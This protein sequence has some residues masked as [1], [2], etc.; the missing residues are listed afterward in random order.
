MEIRVERSF[1]AG[2]QRQDIEPLPARTEH[3]RTHD[4]HDPLPGVRPVRQDLEH[5][6]SARRRHELDSEERR[7]PAPRSRMRL[8]YVVPRTRDTSSTAPSGKVA[9][10]ST[11]EPDSHAVRIAG[12][13]MCSNPIGVFA[14]QVPTNALYQTVILDNPVFATTHI[15]VHSA[16][17]E[18]RQDIGSG[19][20]RQEHRDHAQRSVRNHANENR[21]VLFFMPAI[22]LVGTQ[23]QQ[24]D[25]STIHSRPDLGRPTISRK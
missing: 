15:H 11:R 19:S 22:N 21:V 18:R 6:S 9:R 7:R 25:A 12:P 24:E 16:P 14:L 23:A 20:S 4:T 1:I 3:E 5:G 10:S 2:E 8:G 13:S 17:E